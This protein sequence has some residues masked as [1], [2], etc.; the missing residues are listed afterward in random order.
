MKAMLR[1]K[2]GKRLAVSLITWMSRRSSFEYRVLCTCFALF[3]MGSIY[4]ASRQGLSA[5]FTPL[6]SE[7]G[8]NGGY[9]KLQAQLAATKN[10]I[11]TIDRQISV[12][13]RSFSALATQ[14]GALSL[15]TVSFIDRAAQ[16]TSVRIGKL[17]AVTTGDIDT[18][19][20][21]ERYRL[22]VSGRYQEIVDFVSRLSNEGSPL[23]V[24]QVSIDN[25]NG[26]YP[27]RSLEVQLII[28]RFS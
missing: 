15:D 16:N 14:S 9:R 3:G 21:A 25:S 27:E 24:T 20:L 10:K 23:I 1:S 4:L 19:G 26:G 2:W 28:E 13:R 5:C 11:A 17:Q 6:L 8:P 18:T 12:Y 7:Q 22:A